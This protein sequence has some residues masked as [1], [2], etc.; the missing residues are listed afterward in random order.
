MDHVLTTVVVGLLDRFS[1]L[2]VRLLVI[3]PSSARRR[4]LEGVDRTVRVVAPDRA[5]QV[6]DALDDI[7][8]ELDRR[9]LDPAV[10][11]PR[12][13]VLISDLA[14]LRRQHEGN[15]LGDRID[16]VLATAAA[17]GS[18]VDVIAAVAD[19]DAAGPF[20]NAAA[21]RLVGASSNHADLAALGVERPSEL[22]GIAG[23]CRGFPDGD[24]VQIAV[25]DVDLEALLARRTEGEHR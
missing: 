22:D 25:A 12:L 14:Q 1:D 15:A 20:A 6:A 5:D 16:D 4:A 10:T 24:L 23:R 8:G 9:P 3:E 7:A 13:V 19:L 21:N 17:T 18:G 2:D 11:G